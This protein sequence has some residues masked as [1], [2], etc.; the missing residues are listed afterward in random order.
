M[1]KGR[2]RPARFHSNHDGDTVTMILDQGFYDTKQITLRLA[3]VWAPELIKDTGGPEVWSFVFQWFTKR[4]SDNGWDFV[5]TTYLT[6]TGRDVKTLDRYVADVVAVKDGAHL[7]SDVM[8]YVAE[9]G[10]SGG[11]GS[12]SKS[13]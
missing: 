5:V 4:L 9:K 10:Y 12:P 3:N 8:K 11:I 7:N 2:D 13:T 6:K 1:G